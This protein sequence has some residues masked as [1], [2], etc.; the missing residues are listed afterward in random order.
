M[1]SA[2]TN[3]TKLQNW[4]PQKGFGFAIVDGVRHFVHVTALVP[5]PGRGADL[6]GT[7]IVVE[8]TEVVVGKGPRV[9]RALLPHESGRFRLGDME[10]RGFARIQELPNWATREN[11][12]WQER[13]REGGWGGYITANKLAIC[14]SSCFA[15]K[16]IIWVMEG[17]EAKP[18]ID[19]VMSCVEGQSTRIKGGAFLRR[20]LAANH[21]WYTPKP[22]GRL[23]NF[24][25][26]TPPVPWAD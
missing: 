12:I 17:S 1:E 2:M 14:I 20:W 15:E 23:K 16:D 19:T 25:P 22:E 8:A 7:S 6:N 9:T 18:W 26:G 24:L 3:V 10:F 21:Q 5:R 13:T 4:N 11:H